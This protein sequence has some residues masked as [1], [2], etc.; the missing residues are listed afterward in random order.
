MARDVAPDLIA[1]FD[2]F[3]SYYPT[4]VERRRGDRLEALNGLAIDLAAW[5]ALAAPGDEPGLVERLFAAGALTID[6]HLF[7]WQ[8]LFESSAALDVTAYLKRLPAEVDGASADEGWE[9]DA[10]A[11]PAGV[12][13]GVREFADRLR[14]G[15]ATHAAARELAATT[16]LAAIAIVAAHPDD[17][18]EFGP[19][20]VLSSSLLYV[21]TGRLVLPHPELRDDVAGLF[22]IVH[23]EMPAVIDHVR[24]HAEGEI[25]HDHDGELHDEEDEED[26]D[27]VPPLAE[28]LA[29]LDRALATIEQAAPGAEI[30]R[31]LS[32]L[33]LATSL[34]SEVPEVFGLSSEWRLLAAV[35]ALHPSS[36]GDISAEIKYFD[37]DA[38]RTYV[39]QAA[40]LAA[41][42]LPA[43]ARD[44]VSVDDSLANLEAI[45]RELQLAAAEW[46][47]LE[48][49]PV[50]GLALVAAT[51]EVL[52]I[53][54]QLGDED[55]GVAAAA[56]TIDPLSLTD[57]PDLRRAAAGR[58]KEVA[59][60][61]GELPPHSDE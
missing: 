54:I 16:A 25:D 13:P 26:D 34:T 1:H 51:A 47:S 41:L 42:E 37:A 27:E 45:I 23:E 15:E 18:G 52:R 22:S 2:E 21:L 39:E 28:Q 12:L 6:P 50:G 3:L 19:A 24:A 9:A 4:I 59:Q 48:D 38:M 35:A 8:A 32:S 5:A 53:A 43:A 20:L 40:E 10:E 44:V 46:D 58:L 31:T 57:R 33:L 7:S 55:P 61:V 56:N 29:D 17:D 14:K 60:I 30:A 11:A 36:F 49:S